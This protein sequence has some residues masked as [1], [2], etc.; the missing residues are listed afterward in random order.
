M[1][2]NLETKK[3]LVL[4]AMD[5]YSE[6]TMTLSNSISEIQNDKLQKELNNTVKA[7]TSILEAYNQHR[8]AMFEEHGW[9]V[10]KDK[11]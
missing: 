2:S 11:E 6:C 4:K 1:K 8:T 7:V 10:Y 9:E 3:E 5:H